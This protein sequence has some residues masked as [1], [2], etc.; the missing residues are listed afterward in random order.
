M[1]TPWE[2]KLAKIA[3]TMQGSVAPGGLS[4][5]NAGATFR[6]NPLMGQ[7]AVAAPVASA[8]PA[9]GGLMGQGGDGQMARMAQMPG[10]NY[11]PPPTGPAPVPVAAAGA[12]GAGGVPLSQWGQD[13]RLALLRGRQTMNN[14]NAFNSFQGQGAYNKGF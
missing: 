12:A 11:V 8:A 5:G 6:T 3:Q 1:P 9:S 4:L 2:Q 13:D 7:P 14:R 10:F